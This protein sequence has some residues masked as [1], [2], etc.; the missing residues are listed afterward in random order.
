[1]KTIKVNNNYKKY[2]KLEQTI[3][4]SCD[5]GECYID[6]QIPVS[7]IEIDFK[8]KVEITPQ[9]PENFIL[10]GNNSKILIFSLQGLTLSSGLI[11]TYRGS[12]KILNFIA[13]NE[14]GERLQETFKKGNL[15]WDTLNFNNDQEDLTWNKIKDKNKKGN[16]FQTKYN[17]PDYKLPKVDKKQL[18]QIRRRATTTTPTYTTGGGSTGGSGGSGGY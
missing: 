13:C 14:K 17:L 4:I 15:S 1:M 6:S 18:K 5:N 12:I 7:G 3:T 8:G 16:V 2:N 10:Q 11:F 9:L